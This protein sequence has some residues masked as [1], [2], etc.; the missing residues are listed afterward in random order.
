[1]TLDHAEFD[2][3]M[4]QQKARARNAASVETDDWTVV[5]EGEQELLVMTH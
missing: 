5:N 1:M 3:E 4:A 2:A